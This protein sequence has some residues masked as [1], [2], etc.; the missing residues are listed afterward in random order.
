MFSELAW[1]HST[2]GHPE[3]EKVLEPLPKS[4]ERVAM[5]YPNSPALIE[6]D[7]TYTFSELLH[8][9]KI[10]AAEIK[11]KSTNTKPIA[12]IQANGIDSIAMWF[13]CSLANKP[14]ILLDSN[15]PIA[16]IKEILKIANCK[17]I[18]ADE[19]TLAYASQ[20][21]D[22]DIIT[23]DGKT[24]KVGNLATLQANAVSMIFP[25]SGSTGTPKLIAYASITI[26]AK[27]QSS[28]HLMQV[29]AG[30]KV[31]IASSHS[32]YGY[33]HHALVF[34]LSG[35]CICLADIDNQGFSSTIRAIEYLGAKHARFTPSLFRKLAIMPQALPALQLLNAV[36][37]SG[38]P[39]LA[40]DIRLAQKVLNEDC[41][42]QNVYGSTE[43]ALFIWTKPNGFMAQPEEAIPIGEIYPY[44]SFAIRPLAGNTSD[45]HIGELCISSLFQALGD[46]ENGEV[47][48]DRFFIN[49]NH[50][51][52]RVYATGDLV[53][54]AADGQ[55]I[56]LGRIGR[57]AKIRGQRVYLDEIENHL[58]DIFNIT[59]A[60][61][62][63]RKENEEDVLYG[64][65]STQAQDFNEEQLRAILR[66]TLP[67]YMVPKKIINLAEIPL[68]TGGKVDYMLLEKHL[69]LIIEKKQQPADV[70]SEYECICSIWDSVLWEKAHLHKADFISLGG[71][72][73]GLMILAA[74]IE[75]KLNKQIS[76]E[77]FKEQS[78]FNHLTKLLN[79]KSPKEE[80]AP[81]IGN[82]YLKLF[83]RSKHTSN[84][85]VLVLPG[86]KGWSPAYLFKE[87]GMFS[88]YEIW[89]ADYYVGKENMLNET[90]CL[91]AIEQITACLINKDISKPI[92]I[93]GYSF[94]GGFA[95]L[96]GRYWVKLNL[97]NP[98]II[99][100]DAKPLHRKKVFKTTNFIQRLGLNLAIEM[101]PI[102]HIKK[103]MTDDEL[104]LKYPFEQWQLEDQ[105]MSEIQLP[106]IDHLEMIRIE[107]LKL[108]KDYVDSFIS[109]PKQ[110]KI[111][112]PLQT[113][114]Q[115]IGEKVLNAI[116]G[117]QSSL[118][119]VYVA[120]CT[121]KALLQ[122]PYLISIF[123][124]LY[125]KNEFQKANA[126]IEIAVKK[127]PNSRLLQFI[128]LRLNRKNNWLIKSSNL[129][130]LPKPI[131]AVENKLAKI[132]RGKKW[133]I[134]LPLKLAILYW[135]VFKAFIKASIKT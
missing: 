131:I 5:L 70:H 64:F 8:R 132:N 18:F 30:D 59:N 84:G 26:Q 66:T 85:V 37:F 82:L 57:M 1:H 41:L 120:I 23:S 68:M 79:I 111:N 93:M 28:I 118:D 101:P 49:D 46:Y 89:L 45:L 3:M 115:L 62:T 119:E 2:F 42:I 97:G 4:L 105:I 95:W 55:L 32:N 91:D 10:L 107:M 71:D 81:Q 14:F 50:K 88:D 38:E 53:K 63:S 127:E 74:E 100:L 112:I 113:S 98:M 65:V 47:N 56:H 67:N 34:L 52:E 124:T 48:T 15:Q 43:S 35:A 19:S 54:L 31:V 87:A 90:I 21:S 125:L 58:R 27:V 104:M 96:L 123:F 103:A 126:I 116:H 9:I 29:Q 129:A 108:L 36:R 135:D 6:D 102:L 60:V 78:T 133:M 25:T 128:N 134:S 92:V 122:T 114:P 61:V 24:R 17:E 33:L 20:I 106:T 75:S 77:E 11:E 51:N 7:Y 80:I 72:S 110:E 13:A 22:I 16:R 117:N 83:S 73:M 69:P 109:K 121:Q 99:M 39:L 86:I 130:L 40:S 76:I 44:A 94:G 12:L